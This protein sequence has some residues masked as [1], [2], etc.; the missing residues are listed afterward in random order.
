MNHALT[1]DTLAHERRPSV[2]ISYA[3]EDQTQAFRLVEDL[4]AEGRV[5]WI[6]AR[7][8]HYGDNRWYTMIAEGINNS[9]A[10]VPLIS[11]Q[12]LSSNWVLDEICW[13]LEREKLIFPL[14]LED[15]SADPRFFRLIRFLRV[16]FFG[17][18]YEEALAELLRVL[19]AA[20]TPRVRAVRTQR[21]VESAYLERLLVEE[22]LLHTDKYTPLAG[23]SQRQA[24]RAE[25][26][27]VFELMPLRLGQAPHEA[28]APR[29]FEN[30][31]E[32]IRK[33]RRAVLLGEP[34]AG[35]TTTLWKLAADLVERARQDVKA[36][37][38]LL[39]RL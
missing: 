31:V 7:R 30:A 16:Q 21:E 5:C 23:A 1:N 28:Q 39:V 38:P 27:A 25:M 4:Q 20:P 24:Q 37:I 19:P 15:V 35:K 34:G 3:H 29:R 11:E 6:D 2:F 9:Y 8:I 33:L 17:R 22:K 14:M 36:P 13:A 10:F 26:R 12:A 32:E 18:A